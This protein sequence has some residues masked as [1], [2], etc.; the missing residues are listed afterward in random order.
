M[1]INIVHCSKQ[2]SINRTADAISNIYSDENV[3][4]DLLLSN[5]FEPF[6]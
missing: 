5:A 2:I 4:I 6:D 1:K 3:L